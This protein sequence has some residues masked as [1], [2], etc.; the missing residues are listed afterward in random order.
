MA[1]IVSSIYFFPSYFV[2]L[3]R[4]LVVVPLLIGI[5]V[6]HTVLF[7][8]REISGRKIFYDISRYL[9]IALFL[10]I[11]Y[12]SGGIHSQ[13]LFLLFFPI[14][15]SGTDLDA[16]ET[17]RVG[18]TTS[19][20]FAVMIFA[21][22]FDSLSPADI[23][24]HILRAFVFAVSAY[25]MYKIVKETLLQKYE[26][27]ETKRKF[28][29]LIELEK[30]KGDFI[31]VA[32]HQLRTPLSGLKWGLANL[33]EDESMSPQS[34]EVV[35]QSL[36]AVA[37]ATSIVNDLIASSEAKIPDF[38][39]QKNKFDLSELLQEIA[40]DLGFLVRSKGVKLDVPHLKH[41]TIFADRDK[42]KPVLT[43][44]LDNAIRYSPGKTV[45]VFVSADEKHATIK[46]K[47]TGIG[48]SA[49]DLPHVFDRFYRSKQ[50]I[51]LEPNETG[52]GLYISKSII[53]KHGGTIDIVSRE[54]E[55]T[56]VTV[57][58]PRA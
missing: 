19:I 13:F 25:Y 8:L 33:S 40:G 11:V 39:L 53:E 9:W 24:K 29:E 12:T 10:A 5:L 45:S 43:N 2:F 27:E 6:S 22:P 26:K 38:H 34:K 41:V 35:R 32:S 20:V 31:T 42:L 7:I 47:D 37:R 52:V 28:V 17:K 49:E 3:G 1:L 57:R 48:I 54:G 44:V 23:V 16:R 58:L 14:L 4:S 56:E 46:V 36:E 55:G 30:V 15:T 51:S 21:V 50:A 18:I